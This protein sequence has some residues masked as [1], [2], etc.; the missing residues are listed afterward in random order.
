MTN[1]IFDAGFSGTTA[2]FCGTQATPGAPLL[3]N[4]SNSFSRGMIDWGYAEPADNGQTG[5]AALRPSGSGAYKMA[6]TLSP[7][8]P[9]QVT[10]AGRKVIMA[11]LDLGGG[12][13]GG[14]LPRDLSMD[15][16]TGELLQQF[17]PE[18]QALRT[19]SG[20][21]ADAASLQI[22]VIADFTLGPGVNTSTA[23]FGFDV[24]V[25]ADGTDRQSVRVQLGE[26]IVFAGGK[27]GPL[28]PAAP[29][30]GATI[31]V[32]A[33]V[34]HCILTVFVNNRTAITTFVAPRD[35]NSVGIELTGV[36]G[37]TVTAVWQAWVLRD[38]N[39]TYAPSS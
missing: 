17:A 37:V 13:Q 27:A 33:I 20:N 34:D 6:R 1:N 30:P 21:P 38:A 18:L 26:Q 28:Q 14:S 11:W 12:G 15:A 32:H 8:S 31:H 10:G 39:I 25:S 7:S 4:E 24:L 3:V 23:A 29:A 2:F 16:S 36:D 19:G 5:I 35:A 9:N 22:E